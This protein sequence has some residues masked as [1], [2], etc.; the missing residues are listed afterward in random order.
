MNFRSTFVIVSLFILFSAFSAES[1]YQVLK[2]NVSYFFNKY[3]L[4]NKGKETAKEIVNEKNY[5]IKVDSIDIKKQIEEVA[6][7]IE[8]E[9]EKINENGTNNEPVETVSLNKNEEQSVHGFEVEL[10]KANENQNRTHN[11]HMEIGVSMKNDE[12]VV[13]SVEGELKNENNIEKVNESK[14]KNTLV[15]KNTT[16]L[17]NISNIMHKKFNQTWNLMTYGYNILIQKNLLKK[18]IQ[19]AMVFKFIH[20]ML[21]MN[22]LYIEFKKRE[23]LQFLKMKKSKKIEKPIPTIQQTNESTKSLETKRFRVSVGLIS[24]VV[25]LYGL[26]I[27]IIL[28]VIVVKIMRKRK[29]S[30]YID[31]DSNETAS[32][33]E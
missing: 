30:G 11:E 33:T 25:S 28:A 20:I 26:A 16:V 2:N 10:Q 23:I 15:A 8:M 14:N 17:H 9:L 32:E 24:T 18:L 29:R 12:K 22:K 31:I 3:V 4:P 21:K 5:K 13:N 19:L 1:N 6:A 27:I 7:V